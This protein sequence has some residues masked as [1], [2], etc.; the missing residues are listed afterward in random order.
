MENVQLLM[1]GMVP[2]GGMVVVSYTLHV[3]DRRSDIENFLKVASDS[4]SATRDQKKEGATTGYILHNDRQIEE[5][6]AK[7][8]VVGKGGIL[9][10][11][12]QAWTL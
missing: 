12:V 8:I 2:L 1:R 3:A 7:R 10:V 9:G 11:E 5:L 6:H 4:I